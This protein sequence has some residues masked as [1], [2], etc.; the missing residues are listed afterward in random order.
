MDLPALLACP[1]PSIAGWL[2]WDS[3]MPQ[4]RKDTMMMDMKK[5]Q[6]FNTDGISAND[7]WAMN[8]GCTDGF[9]YQ[10]RKQLSWKRS[11]GQ[12]TRGSGYKDGNIVEYHVNTVD[13]QK[14]KETPFRGDLSIRFPRG[15]K[16]LKIFGH[17]EC[18]FKKGYNFCI[19]FHKSVRK[20]INCQSKELVIFSAI[21]IFYSCKEATSI[22]F[23]NVCKHVYSKLSNY[24]INI[25]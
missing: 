16:P 13:P 23:L 8:K 10:P 3:D 9:R 11:K 14:L 20:Y 1:P 15:A 18:V 25:P 22:V 6:H 2:G 4:G 12:V 24:H 17:D 7:I 19:T 5:L 21:R